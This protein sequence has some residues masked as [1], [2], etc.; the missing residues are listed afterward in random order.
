M[1]WHLYI[2]KLKVL[3]F[4]N[5]TPRAIV[6]KVTD[7]NGY[8]FTGLETVAWAKLTAVSVQKWMSQK[9]LKAEN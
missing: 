8:Q 1:L 3:F 5:S 9:S 6:L 2:Y 4:I 7:D